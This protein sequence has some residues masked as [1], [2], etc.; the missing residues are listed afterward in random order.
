M[1]F[2]DGH[3]ILRPITF[4]G[5]S[6]CAI[7]KYRLY[8]HIF[9]ANCRDIRP[10]V[11]H[12]HFGVKIQDNLRSSIRNNLLYGIQLWPIS[13]LSLS[14]MPTVRWASSSYCA[15]R[16]SF[17]TFPDVGLYWW[18]WANVSSTYGAMMYYLTL[19]QFLN[20]PS[21]HTCADYLIMSE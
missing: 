10:E 20:N 8:S 13:D 21:L 7:Y 2:R 6:Q 1:D 11:Q 4:V 16:N 19:F 14:S 12:F 5:R 17:N 9:L 18:Q 3:R 15:L